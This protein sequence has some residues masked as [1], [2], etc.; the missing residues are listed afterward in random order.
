MKREAT[1][2]PVSVRTG[3]VERLTPRNNYCLAKGNS[4][5]AGSGENILAQSPSSNE[6]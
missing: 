4:K 6:P 5:E 3:C 2:A 1:D